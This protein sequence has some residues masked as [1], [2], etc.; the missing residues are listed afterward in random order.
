MENNNEPLPGSTRRL[1]I[2]RSPTHLL[3]VDQRD[4]RSRA[5]CLCTKACSRSSV[6]EA[7]DFGGAASRFWPAGRD[8]GRPDRGGSLQF[9]QWYSVPSK[10]MRQ[11]PISGTLPPQRARSEERRVGKESIYRG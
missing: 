7:H 8:N 2:T 10:W 9:T 1:A 4:H 3:F 5:C 6:F 11:L